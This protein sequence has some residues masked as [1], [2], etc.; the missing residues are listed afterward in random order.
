MRTTLCAR[1]SLPLAL[2]S[3]ILSNSDDLLQGAAKGIANAFTQTHRPIRNQ[4]VVGLSQERHLSQMMHR[5]PR[6]RKRMRENGS[7][8]FLMMKRMKMILTLTIGLLPRVKT[9]AIHPIPQGRC[10]IKA[11]RHQPKL[12]LRCPRQRAHLSPA[13]VAHRLP[14]LDLQRRVLQPGPG[15]FNSTWITSKIM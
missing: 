3:Y 12:H 10:S 11:R 2:F 9:C 13:E 14:R 5:P 7:L 8:L 15:I 1:V 4:V 6:I